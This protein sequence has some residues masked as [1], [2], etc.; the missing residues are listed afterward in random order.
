M[1]KSMKR[2][3]QHLRFKYLPILADGKLS[4]LLVVL[5]DVTSE[6]AREKA[7]ASQRELLS[8]FE[9][10]MKVIRMGLG[11]ELLPRRTLS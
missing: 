1:P 7:D 5:S 6:M 8:V 2:G 4:K 10:F 9:F 3:E 11:G